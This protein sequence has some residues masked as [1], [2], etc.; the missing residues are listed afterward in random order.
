MRS[1]FCCW[2]LISLNCKWKDLVVRYWCRLLGVSVWNFKQMLKINK[3]LIEK[4]NNHNLLSW[5]KG[6][7]HNF[8]QLIELAT[9]INYDYATANTW[10]RNR[11]QWTC[12]RFRYFQQFQQISSI[13]LNKPFS[14]A[15]F[16]TTIYYRFSSCKHKSISLF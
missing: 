15:L 2:Y 12:S 6:H 9:C 5:Q 14:I 16:A 3:K 10:G 7:Y 4:K 1:I 8:K 13:E 11:R